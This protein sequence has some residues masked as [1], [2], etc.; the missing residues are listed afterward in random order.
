MINQCQKNEIYVIFKRK[1]FNF[2]LDNF[3]P[4][5]VC[6][7]SNVDTFLN[8]KCLEPLLAIICFELVLPRFQQNVLAKVE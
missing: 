2:L 1:I 5:R 8:S 7:F 6:L 3:T 4:A